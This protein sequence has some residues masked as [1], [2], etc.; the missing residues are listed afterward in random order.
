M[1]RDIDAGPPPI[2]RRRRGLVRSRPGSTTP[3]SGLARS[4]SS[5]S[6][7]RAERFA[8]TSWRW[9]AQRRSRPS[10]RPGTRPAGRGPRR[11]PCFTRWGRS[12]RLRV[13]RA[14]APTRCCRMPITG[15]PYEEI[16]RQSPW[17]FIPGAV[18]DVGSRGGPAEPFFGVSA[19]LAG[20]IQLAE[21][22][23]L[24]PAL[25]GH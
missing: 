21:C 2:S 4:A 3:S 1:S 20:A 25:T 13:C 5:T 10:R 23:G 11:L 16:G 19:S 15:R 14:S 24:L 17:F 6:I 8:G 18:V 22:H 9:G 7:W 12:R